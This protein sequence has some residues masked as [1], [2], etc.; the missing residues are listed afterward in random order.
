ME[1]RN[2]PTTS[3]S[4]MDLILLRVV[5]LLWQ[6]QKPPAGGIVQGL[7]PLSGLSFRGITFCLLGSFVV[8][9]LA[10]RG[11]GRDG[12]N[13]NYWET[14]TNKFIV[15]ILDSVGGRKEEDESGE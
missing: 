1:N 15:Q 13:Y 8:V 14:L 5:S 9:V 2:F 3:F 7:N 4:I 12:D 10:A 11:G 6:P